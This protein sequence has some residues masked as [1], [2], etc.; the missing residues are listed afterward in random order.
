MDINSKI[1]NGRPKGDLSFMWNK[2]LDAAISIINFPSDRLLGLQLRLDNSNLL[3][4]NVYMPWE[5]P[6]NAD[7]YGETLGEIHSI[8]DD[9]EADYVCIIGDLNADPN[10][11]FF[12]PFTPTHILA[13]YHP[14]P[15][16]F[17]L[18]FLKR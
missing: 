16:P 3:I 18:E 11:Q 12:N 6:S 13:K 2:C 17:S 8:I 7:H 9:S 15:R 10:H 1:V 14:A 5:C 4:I